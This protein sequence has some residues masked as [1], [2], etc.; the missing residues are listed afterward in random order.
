[1][2]I[3]FGVIPLL[4]LLLIG[5]SREENKAEASSAKTP[6][7]VAVETVA[8]QTRLIDKTISVTGALHPD[9]SV[10]VSSEVPGR[11]TAIH[12]DFGQSGAPGT[13]GRRTRPAGIESGC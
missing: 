4:C 9:E 10:S 12:V 1:M 7:P 11:I 6:E 8:A 13:S 5:C 3:R 2:T